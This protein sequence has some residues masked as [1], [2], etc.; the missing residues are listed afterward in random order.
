MFGLERRCD[1]CWDEKGEDL[2]AGMIMEE[3]RYLL[4]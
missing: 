4:G 1:I 2:Y 3:I